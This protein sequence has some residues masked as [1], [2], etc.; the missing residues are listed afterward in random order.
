MSICGIFTFQVLAIYFIFAFLTYVHFRGFTFLLLPDYKGW[1]S[2]FP[3][4][5]VSIL[6]LEFR[7]WIFVTS[8]SVLLNKWWR[9]SCTSSYG[10]SSTCAGSWFP[11]VLLTQSHPD[12][13]IFPKSQRNQ[14]GLDSSAAYRAASH[15]SRCRK[16]NHFESRNWLF[17]IPEPFVYRSML[18]NTH[19][20]HGE[21]PPQKAKLLKQILT[22][23]VYCYWQN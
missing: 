6:V 4:A 21:V 9:P 12:Y 17:P 13:N 23:V 2:I 15:S 19:G 7:M 3:L 10:S 1:I 11:H 18:Q 20:S 16:N 8:D 22:N 5:T 14:S